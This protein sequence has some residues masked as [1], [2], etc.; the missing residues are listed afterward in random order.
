M[1]TKYTYKNVK[2]AVNGAVVAAA[3]FAGS[4]AA[5]F[6]D[7]PELAAGVAVFGTAVTGFTVFLTKWEAKADPFGD[8]VD[9]ALEQ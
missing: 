6:A 7:F 9:N 8:A 5:A 1:A 2:K 4:L 3:T